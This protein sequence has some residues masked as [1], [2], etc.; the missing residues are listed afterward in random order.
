[1]ELW[2]GFRCE[3]FSF[4]ERDGVIVFPPERSAIGRLAVKM[5]YWG[6]FPSAVE[7]PLLEK[8]FHLCFLKNDHRWGGDGDL[9]RK[10]QFIRFLCEK[11]R[12]SEKTVPVGMSCGGL[13]A[14]KFA[15][16]YP[17]L[18]SCLYLDAPVLNYMSCPCGFGIGEPLYGPGTDR[19]IQEIMAALELSGI[20]ELI[21]YREMP[22]DCI[23]ALVA[24]QIPVAMVAG[25][26]DRVVPF[27]ENGLLLQRA[28]RKA[29]LPLFFAMK[30]NC[31]HHP[32]GLD[33]TQHLVDFILAHSGAGLAAM[34]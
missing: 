22:M 20:S 25:D 13:M 34:R 28:Y 24:S 9:D 26:A 6:A 12:L 30:E 32:H 15:A 23:P 19:G 7:I 17:E 8:G 16:K 1:M 14:I 31:G 21:S 11:Y 33:D 3:R 10:A 4:A 27:E 29:V 5:E 18:V 2:N